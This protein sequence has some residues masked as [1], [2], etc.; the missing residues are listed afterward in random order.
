[1][2]LRVGIET[3]AARRRRRRED[4]FRVMEGGRDE[5]GD[6]GRVGDGAE[7]VRALGDGAQVM[8]SATT[9]S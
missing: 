1:M 7:V 4:V 6:S 8:D 2:M 3:G 9:H 5:D